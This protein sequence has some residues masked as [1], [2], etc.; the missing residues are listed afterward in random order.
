[1]S[2]LADSLPNLILSSTSKRI[3]SGHLVFQLYLFSAT[4]LAT[5]VYAQQRFSEGNFCRREEASETPWSQKDLRSFVRWTSRRQTL[6]NDENRRKVHE[7]LT[8][9]DGEGPSSWS[10]VFLQRFEHFPRRLPSAVD[11]TRVR[12]TQLRNRWGQSKGNHRNLRSLV[13]YSQQCPFRFL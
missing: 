13:E 1:M 6:A 12:T 10:R 2:C 11:Y 8:L 4:V 3:V 7:V 9:Q 5:R